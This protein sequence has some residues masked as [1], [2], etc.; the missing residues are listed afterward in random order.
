MS[1]FN[2][3]RYMRRI[4]FPACT[5]SRVITGRSWAATSTEGLLIYSL[6]HNL[7]FDPY[8]L[9]M[10]ITPNNV[11]KTLQEEEYSTAVM[12]AFRLNENALIQ[13]VVETIPVKEGQNSL[14]RYLTLII[15]FDFQIF[16]VKY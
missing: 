12:L 2:L 10:E 14:F 4:S 7:V 8:D 11:K 16:R 6:D 3:I 5:D 1:E 13:E 9:E 15:F